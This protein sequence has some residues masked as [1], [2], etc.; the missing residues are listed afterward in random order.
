[1]VGLLAEGL[2]RQERPWG[3]FSLLT[4]RLAAIASDG[5]IPLRLTRLLSRMDDDRMDDDRMEA[6]L[7]RFRSAGG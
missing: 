2:V 1:M 3:Q 6:K 5:W 7:H 4:D